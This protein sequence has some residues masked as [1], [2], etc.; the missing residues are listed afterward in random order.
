MST[1]ERPKVGDIAVCRDGHLGIVTSIK[2]RECGIAGTE[3]TWHGFHVDQDD[4][5]KQ[6]ESKDP[7]KVISLRGVL[8]SYLQQD[9]YVLEKTL[10]N[11]IEQLLDRQAAA[12]HFYHEAVSEGWDLT[13]ELKLWP[14]L[15]GNEECEN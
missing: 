13:S 2:S 8:L 6:W 5:G 11:A 4:A 10:N 3:I 14:W 9:N 1:T 12:E 15:E 7:T